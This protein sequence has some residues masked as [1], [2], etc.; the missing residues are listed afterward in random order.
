MGMIVCL[1]DAETQSPD[2][3]SIV[4]RASMIGDEILGNLAGNKESNKQKVKRKRHSSQELPRR[5]IGR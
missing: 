2:S 4:R 3:T 1:S 5:E